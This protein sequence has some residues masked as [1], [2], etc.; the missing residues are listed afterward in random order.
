MSLRAPGAKTS[1]PSSRIHDCHQG[2]E[3][4]T[5]L[6]RSEF[7]S[8]NV[9]IKVIKTNKNNLLNVKNDPLAKHGYMDL[10]AAVKLTQTGNG[11]AF[12]V[13]VTPFETC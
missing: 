2:T 11:A 5:E 1:A 8:S 13:K 4:E 12:K 10:P 7:K 3:N 6:L 9:R